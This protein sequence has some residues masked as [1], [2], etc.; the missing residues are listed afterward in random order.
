MQLD[1][2][3]LA[4][5]IRTTFAVAVTLIGIVWLF[6]TIRILEFVVNRGAPFIDFIVMS[7]MVIPLWLTIAIPISAFIATT[8]VFQR[9]LSDRELL[10]M[11][12]SGQS[13]FQLARAPIALGLGMMAILLLNSVVILPLSFGIY[14]DLQFKL[15]SSVPSILL[16]DG[17][18]IDVVD[19]MTMFIGKKND[20]GLAT[21][22]F[23]HDERTA[24]K[25]VTITAKKGNFIKKE[26]MPAVILQNGL[27]TE[28]NDNGEAG[29]TLFFDTHTVMITARD[30]QN[31][32]RMP[33]DMNEDTISNLLD[34]AKSPSESYF[35]QRRAEGHYRIIS[36]VLALVLVLVAGCSVLCGQI[37][38]DTWSRRVVLNLVG[39]ILAISILVSSRSIATTISSAIPLLYL[40][41]I[42]PALI[43]LGMLIRPSLMSARALSGTSTSG[44]LEAKSGAMT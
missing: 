12:A 43:L 9:I 18:F 6:Q 4:Q 14:K 37:R 11:Q 13:A 35:N 8:W 27:R 33:I 30:R 31:V 28:L 41:M 25:T 17:V 34:P 24:N 26:G 39:A 10:V 22:I 21:D 36:P 7:I 23:I 29:A 32:M 42:T 44:E 15:R 2:Y 40:G 20:G 5:L 16:Q 19:G 3:L 1:R 38:R